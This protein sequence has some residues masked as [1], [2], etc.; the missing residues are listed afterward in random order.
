MI[1]SLEK[2]S[3]LSMDMLASVNR[4]KRLNEADKTIDKRTN[5]GQRRKEAV[6]HKPDAA[7]SL[8]HEALNA[9]I[10]AQYVLMDIQSKK[11]NYYIERSR[12]TERTAKKSNTV[13]LM[14]LI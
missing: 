9:G 6:M 12:K 5:V 3:I 4:E 10:T 1:L 13:L 14:A 7:I 11:W 2:N 8:I